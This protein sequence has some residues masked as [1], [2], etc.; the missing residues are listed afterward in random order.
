MRL[1]VTPFY[2][3][4]SPMSFGQF[5]RMESD[6]PWSTAVDK[7]ATEA[8]IRGLSC[9]FNHKWT[10]KGTNPTFWRG[11]IVTRYTNAHQCVGYETSTR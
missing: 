9:D 11:G 5:S 2:S 3:Q 4:E 8:H 10:F 7:A 1:T 6:V